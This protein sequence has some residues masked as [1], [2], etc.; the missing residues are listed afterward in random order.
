VIA[1][2]HVD[3]ERATGRLCHQVI[4]DT[5][6]PCADC[7][8]ARLAPGETATEVLAVAGGPAMLQRAVRKTATTAQISYIRLGDD[9]ITKL[10][11]S[12]LDALAARCRLSQRE[13]EVL[14]ELVTGRSLDEI[15]RVLRISTRTVRFHQTNVLS[16]LGI[17]SR[18]ELIHAILQ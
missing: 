3:D 17:Q 6:T 15:A 1:A 2:R 11:G 7:P 14:D 8:I 10:F 12:R 5:D 13:R 4:F 18:L 9:M 16:K